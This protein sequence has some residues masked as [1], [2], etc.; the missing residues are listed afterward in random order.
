MGI[1]TTTTATII[2]DSIETECIA[3]NASVIHI[4]STNVVQVDGSPVEIPNDED[5]IDRFDDEV[6]PYSKQIS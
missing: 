6:L 5:T 1:E 3:T 2:T 4:D